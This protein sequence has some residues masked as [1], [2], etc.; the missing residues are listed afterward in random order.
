V[1]E[2]LRRWVPRRAQV[3]VGL[4][5][6]LVVSGAVAHARNRVWNSAI[7]LWEDSAR[8]S[9]NK[10]RPNFQLAFTYYSHGRCADALRMYERVAK[11]G[12][13]DYRLLVDW[14]LA[15][16]CLNRRGEALAKL[17]QVPEKNAHV[18]SLIGMVHLKERRFA[19]ARAAL[20]TSLKL[21]PNFALS[22]VYRA[23]VHLGYRNLEAA[24]EDYRRAL[25]LNPDS[26]AARKG[27]AAVEARLRAR[28]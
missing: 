16:D 8:K 5:V 23:A 26:D 18:Y 20:D 3:A 14:A 13:H 7:A 28:R 10:S 25:A 9:P 19:Q 17:Q 22:Y 12:P 11:L 21:D 27:L 6:V 24:A 1:L 15:Y 2:F 4:A